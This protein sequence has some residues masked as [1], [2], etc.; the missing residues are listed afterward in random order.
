[1]TKRIFDLL[2][3]CFVLILCAPILVLVAILIKL[4]SPGSVLFAQVRIGRGF[5]PFSQYKFRTMVDD[6]YPDVGTPERKGPP[7]FTRIGRVLHQLKLNE[8]PQFFNVL[9]GEMS[10]VGPRPEAPYFVEK[11]RDEFQEI[12][13]VR[14][15]LMDLAFLASVGALWV[16]GKPVARPYVPEHIYLKETLPEKIRLAQL[17]MEHASFPL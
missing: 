5:R 6:E 13:S 11:F 17:Y 15:G 3:S 1:M 10:V 8:L 4:D 9:K 12:L 2:I 16:G 14:P 7:P